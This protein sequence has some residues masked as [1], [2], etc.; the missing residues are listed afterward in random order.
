[1]NELIDKILIS[2]QPNDS[3][4][5]LKKSL[6]NSGVVLYHYPMIEIE[7]APISI[8]QQSILK[9]ISKFDWLIFTS[10]NGVKYFLKKLLNIYGTISL[11][12]SIKTAVIG[13]KTANEL[14]A[15][16][17]NPDFVSKSNYAETFASELKDKVIVSNSNVLLL[18]GNLANTTIEDSL[19]H[20]ANISRIDCYNTIDS[21]KKFPELIKKVNDNKYDLILFT[22]SSCFINFANIL[23]KNNISINKIKAVSIGKSTTKTINKFGIEP[24]ITAKQSNIE[25]LINEINNFFKIK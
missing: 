13:N 15:N 20:K 23:N 6:K 4:Y 16:G 1:M 9:N 22:S 2:T 11:P 7:E 19:N 5:E 14:I 21:K 17:I 18:L 8:E 24:L 10:K 25:G 3:F 12:T